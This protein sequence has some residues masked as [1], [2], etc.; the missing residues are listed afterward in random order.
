MNA[1]TRHFA[2]VGLSMFFATVAISLSAQESIP[3]RT[4]KVTVTAD[5]ATAYIAQF[6]TDTDKIYRLKIDG[7]SARGGTECGGARGCGELAGH[8]FTRHEYR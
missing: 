3:T 8:Q 1:M 2:G 6:Q 4:P 7:V 5:G